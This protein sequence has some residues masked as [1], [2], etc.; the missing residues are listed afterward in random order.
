MR[1]KTKKNNNNDQARASKSWNQ[2]RKAGRALTR[3]LQTH[4]YSSS[5]CLCLAP[6]GTRYLSDKKRGLEQRERGTKVWCQTL[7]AAKAGIGLVFLYLCLPPLLCFRVFFH[8]FL[9]YFRYRNTSRFP[10][11]FSSRLCLVQQQQQSALRSIG[12]KG[13][14]AEVVELGWWRDR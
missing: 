3:Q 6:K 12:S 9:C 8:I 4:R 14:A 13:A 10:P 2:S 5:P 7:S 11:L 1:S